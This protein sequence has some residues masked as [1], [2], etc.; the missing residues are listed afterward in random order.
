MSTSPHPEP[1]VVAVVVAYNRR[2]LLVQTLDGLQGQTRPVDAVVV[3]DNASTDGSGDVA[4]AHPLAADVV[5]LS[6]NTGGAGGFAAGIAHALQAHG[7]DLV[8]I[9]DD[10]TVPTGT[11]LLE[12]LLA[13]QAYPGDP[14]VLASRVVWTDGRDHPMNT[15]RPRP[16]VRARLAARARSAGAVQVR[17]ASFVS[18]L[19]DA[20]AVRT[21]GLPMAAYF[22]WND[23][24]EYSARLLRRRVGL[25]VPSSVVRHLTKTFGSTDA[26]PGERFYYE[27]RNKIWLFTRSRALGPA[28]TVLYGGS[29]VV[30]WGR[31]ILKSSNRPV[32]LRAGARGFRDGLA[33]RPDPTPA[34]LAGMGPV[35]DEVAAIERGAGRD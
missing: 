16:G 13:R 30:R 26:D 32:L 33:T 29:T 18:L 17:S 12:L 6:R 20:R 28:G 15:P 35:S 34:V 10:D 7:A 22:I 25:S 8:W 14:A 5:T 23:D 19:L 9:M 24:F 27:V 3:V 31:T 2:D 4:A 1:R 21:D 11:A